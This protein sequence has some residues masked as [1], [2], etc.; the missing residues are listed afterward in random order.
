MIT[1]VE[2]KSPVPPAARNSRLFGPAP[3]RKVLLVSIN[4]P[5]N[6]D[7]YGSLDTFVFGHVPV[8]F[9]IA[10]TAAAAAQMLEENPDIAVLIVDVSGEKGESGLALV[11]KIREEM[12]NRTVRVVLLGETPEDGQ[13]QNRFLD[14]DVSD[15]RDISAINLP[16]LFT[17]L[18]I[19]LQSYERLVSEEDS[20]QSLQTILDITRELYGVRSV[21]DFC[22]TIL[23]QLQVICKNVEDCFFAIP[24]EHSGELSVTAGKGRFLAANKRRVTETVDEDLFEMILAASV[25][26]ENLFTDAVSILCICR[27]D[28][29][30]GV[31]V[32]ENRAPLTFLETR[33]MELICAN[34]TLGLENADMFEEIKRLAFNDSLTGLDSRAKF[35]SDV[36]S[37]IETVAKPMKKRFA[38][39]QFTLEHLPELNIALGHDAGD[40]LL[41]FVS[42]QLTQLFPD[43]I[44]LARTSGNGFGLCLPYMR[45]RELKEIPKVIHR[46][47][48]HGPSSRENMPHISPRIG[49]AL[50]PAD[51]DNGTTLWRNTNIAL[52]NLKVRNGTYFCFY[53]SAIA[54]DINA[55]VEMNNA[56]RAGIMRK[57]LSLNYQ[58]QVN[59]ENGEII[60]VE[61]LIRWQRE[62]GQF[63]APNEFIPV[64]ESSGLIMPIS[65]WVLF[66]ACRQRKE[67]L[68]LG[69]DGW[70][71]AVNLSLSIFQ[72]DD[73]AELIKKT[74]SETGCPPRLLELE[75]TESVIMEN[76]E[77]TL[78]NFRDLRALGVSFAIDDF[79][80]GYSSLSYLRQLPVSSLK[81]DKAFIDG[82]TDN[83]DD[84]AIARTVISLG[85]SLGLT[86]LA[87]GVESMD[88]VEFL[89]SAKCHQA[90]G[91][92]FSRPVAAD[93]ILPFIR[94][95]GFSSFGQ[96]TL[97]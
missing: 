75:V 82:L 83:A 29:L 60:G 50:Y 73:F 17:S 15:Y 4:I 28:R 18:T 43:A 87:E 52:A 89:W 23:T 41:Q 21:E 74:L 69:A 53:N 40:E 32:L 88:Q 47:F 54:N 2:G 91:F 78:G 97:F 36:Q 48:E 9:L 24:N 33:Q 37:Y 84:A 77:Q 95:P 12:G 64:A 16:K 19:A 90:Q 61:A 71:V 80:T 7:P 63:T 67:W 14:Y 46:L 94:N 11:R 65:E 70:R 38:V 86:V 57:D 66:E 27:D 72:N 51:A 34:I 76:P 42:E 13:A 68:D 20:K 59:L 8:V 79:G 45:N 3:R 25:A 22:L 44:S 55:R 1:S 35:R 56:L 10:E 93:E 5:K 85:R 81:I 58:P 39:V 6:N 49:L 62:A 96:P 92:F 26:R 30:K 31:V